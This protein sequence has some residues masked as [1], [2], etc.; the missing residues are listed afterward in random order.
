ME[1]VTRDEQGKAVDGI[2]PPSPEAVQTYR[3]LFAR[4]AQARLAS[5]EERR[6]GARQAALAALPELLAQYPAVRRAYLFGSVLREGAFTAFSDL[7]IALDGADTEMCLEIWREAEKTMADWPLD[8]RPL[9]DSAFAARVR[10][11]GE[12]IYA[13]SSHS[14]QV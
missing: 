1:A 10:K 14:A 13:R 9:D 4:R 6:R 5:R 2:L 8:V 11:K 7:D 12:I 3:R